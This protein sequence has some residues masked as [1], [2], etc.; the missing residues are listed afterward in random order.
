MG[1]GERGRTGCCVNIRNRTLWGPHRCQTEAIRKHDEHTKKNEK[2]Y[3]KQDAQDPTKDVYSEYDHA[4]Y[5][6]E[7]NR[8]ASACFAHGAP[9][10]AEDDC[11]ADYGWKRGC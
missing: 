9:I 3:I 1:E 7:I 2:I 6:L 10:P 11:E 5:E 8:T 4:Y